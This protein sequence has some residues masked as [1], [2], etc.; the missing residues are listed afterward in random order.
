MQLLLEPAGWK[1]EKSES[2]EC[3]ADTGQVSTLPSTFLSAMYCDQV[4]THGDG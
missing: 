4:F 2:R 1:G 3:W